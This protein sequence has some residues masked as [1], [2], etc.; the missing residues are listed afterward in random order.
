VEERVEP[1]AHDLSLSPLHGDLV[2]GEGSEENEESDGIADGPVG[3]NLGNACLHGAGE[4][5]LLDVEQVASGVH[6]CEE[7]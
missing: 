2:L 1:F 6:S 5:I 3:P 4:V 7:S